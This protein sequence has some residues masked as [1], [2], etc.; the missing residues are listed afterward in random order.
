MVKYCNLPP[1]KKKKN[2][3]ELQLI[4]LLH[5]VKRRTKDG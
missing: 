1:K 2:L 4:Y 3:C 5:K